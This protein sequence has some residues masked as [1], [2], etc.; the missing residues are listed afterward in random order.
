VVD[1][2]SSAAFVVLSDEYTWEVGHTYQYYYRD[3]G[4]NQLRQGILSMDNK[5]VID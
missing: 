3:M 4:C 2:V 5:M 1:E